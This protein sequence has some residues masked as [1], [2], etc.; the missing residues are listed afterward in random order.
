MKKT[1]L[2]LFVLI[3]TSTLISAQDLET[4]AVKHYVGKTI[5]A[6]M[7]MPD[8]KSTMVIYPDR[9][10]PFD[11]ELYRLK[12]E[13]VG[14]GLEVGD[15]AIIKSVS[16]DGNDVTFHFI[17]AGDIIPNGKVHP[18]M[19]DKDIWGRGG[20]KVKIKGGNIL[21]ASKSKLTTLNKCLSIVCETKALA[22]A[23][24]LPAA[25]QEA[26]KVGV[27]E[28]GMPK[29]AVYLMM[30]DPTDIIKELRGDLLVEAWIYEKEDFTSIVI[31]FHDG[32]VYLIKEV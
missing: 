18:D 2:V 7:P 13:R 15:L 11:K 26:V 17:G 5:V 12:M 29:K 31:I 28:A 10:M 23:D 27:V 32:K 6:R 4:T 19:M 20:A 8:D 16:V 30:G 22:T 9:D 1:V 24:D 3:F 21:K 25:M 14:V